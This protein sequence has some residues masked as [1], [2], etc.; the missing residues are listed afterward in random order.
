MIQ[1]SGVKQGNSKHLAWEERVLACGCYIGGKIVIYFL[2]GT[3]SETRCQNVE[4]L[5]L[6]WRRSQSSCESGLWSRSTS[7]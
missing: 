4:C 6:Q 5:C 7:A 2:T 3:T 1:I